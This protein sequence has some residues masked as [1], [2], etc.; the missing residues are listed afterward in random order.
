[1]VMMGLNRIVVTDGSIKA[2]VKFDLNIEE[3]SKRH[4][5]K[6]R[7]FDYHSEQTRKTQKAGYWFIKPK[8]NTESKSALDISTDT[9]FEADNERSQE[10]KVK[11]TGNVDLRFKSDYFPLERMVELM[12]VN[13]EAIETN[14][15]QG[16]PQQAAATPPVSQP[17]IPP[18]PTA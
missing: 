7:S 18:L 11:M 6:Q 17:P 10:M 4:Y 14:A 12:G 2:G 1:M 13:Q 16:A 3:L 5:D 9:N 8:I 15:R